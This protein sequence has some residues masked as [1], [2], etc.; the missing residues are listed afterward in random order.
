MSSPAKFHVFLST[1]SSEFQQERVKME[2][3]LE[4]KGLTSPRKKS[5][6]KEVPPFGSG[7]GGR[8]PGGRLRVGYRR[9]LLLLK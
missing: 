3:W 9:L 1:V 7:A 2:E 5:S 6:I 4:K 8:G